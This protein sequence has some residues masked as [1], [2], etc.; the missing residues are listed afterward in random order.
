[1]SEQFDPYYTWLG[2]AP[3]D[4]PPNHY[5]L[6]GVDA[7]EGNADAIANGADRQMTH[8]RSVSMGKHAS[9]AQRILNEISAAR[10]CLLDSE[11]KD[12][13]DRQLKGALAAAKLPR[14]DTA[15]R[16]TAARPRQSNRR[17]RWSTKSQ[18]ILVV[19]GG[20]G[21]VVLAALILMM[22]ANGDNRVSQRKPHDNDRG[23]VIADALSPITSREAKR[24]STG[25]S[26]ATDSEATTNSQKLSSDTSPHGVRNSDGSDLE[27]VAP[28]PPFSRFE[29]TW[30]VKYAN[31]QGRR[32]VI[33]PDGSV[34]HA[35]RTTEM[36]ERDG[37][38]FID[39][40][41]KKLERVKLDGR[42]L[43]VEHFSRP[44]SFPNKPLL[45]TGSR[46]EPVAA[47]LREPFREFEG[48]WLI[49][50]TNGAERQYAIDPSGIVVNGES[51]SR[52]ALKS[53]EV[54]LDFKD[55]TIER[56]EVHANTL[57][58][59]HFNPARKYPWNFIFGS[60]TKQPK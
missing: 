42:V 23:T 47:D 59:E 44:S 56:L 55:G 32:Y 14:A 52:L 48:R 7:F 41:D 27:P 1:M 4:Q 51:T 43:H 17:A 31:G 54:L 19:S 18:F 37:Q 13:Y 29:G 33:G 50:Y 46:V 22:M 3:K 8:L 2:I 39:F 16:L 57:Q 34:I 40:G 26:N 21:G 36:T 45:A 53:G 5:R 38:V 35:D 10:I 30:V 49:K 58:V 15:S 28:Q 20:V 60:G 12:A 24:S 11:K 6:L 9:L 25:S